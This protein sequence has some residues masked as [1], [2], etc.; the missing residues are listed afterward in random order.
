MGLSFLRPGR[1]LL[2]RSPRNYP[3]ALFLAPANFID[4]RNR[5]LQFFQNRILHHFRIDHVLKLDFVERED[6]HHLHEARGQNLPLRQL[7]VQLVL[8]HYH[9]RFNLLL[10]L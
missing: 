3:V 8:Q 2:P 4:Q 5:I 9:T 7:D 6:R 1:A 10:T